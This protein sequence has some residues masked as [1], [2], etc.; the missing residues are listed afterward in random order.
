MGG[1]RPS[2]PIEVRFWRY[3]YKTPNCWFWIG[4]HSPRGYG[5]INREGPYIQAHR[6]AW[7]LLKGEIPTGLDV[8]HKCDIPQC[9]NP[10]HL[11]LGTDADNALDRASKGNGGITANGLKTHCPKGHS[12]DE[13]NTH[14]YRGYRFCKPCSRAKVRARR[15]AQRGR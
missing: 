1:P 7:M 14:W 5:L 6:T 9:V 11:F 4:P 13:L 8:L 10:D 15:E 12:Y 2:L 3:V